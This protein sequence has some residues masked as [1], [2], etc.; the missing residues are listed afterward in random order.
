MTSTDPSPVDL[1]RII[2]SN[3]NTPQVLNDHPWAAVS[4]IEG[5]KQLVGMTLDVFRRIV[6]PSPPRTGK[7]LDTRWGA[8][9]ILAAQYFAPFISGTP[10]PSSLR[11][12]WD[13]LDQAIL[14][15]VHKETDGL[16][17]EEKARY[18]FAGNE[19]Q[20][21]PNSTL[22]DWHRKGMEQLAEMMLVERARK[23]AEK[24]PLSAKNAV[25][26]TIGLAVAS[27]LLAVVLFF[28]W[29]A[30]GLYQHA[31][32]IEQKI[33]AI[34][35]YL[36]PRPDLE[37]LP[38]IGV[39]IHDLRLEIDTL[40]SEAAPY[41]WMTKYGGWIPTYGGT[42]E[43]APDL[44][45]FAQKL[46]IAADDGLSA[47]S[48]AIESSL[49]NNQP[50]EVLDLLLQ[51]QDSSPKLLNAQIALAQAQAARGLIDTSLLL[52][53]LETMITK[54]IDPLLSSISGAFPMED[55]LAMVS[56]A[57]ELLGGGKAGPQTYLILMQNE[58]ELRPT[59]GF[60]TAIGSAVIKDGQLLNI[61]IESSEKVDDFSKPYPIPPW[62]FEEFMNIEML[63]LR[64]SNWFTDFPTTVSWTEY[65][66]SYTRASSS[67]GVISLDMNV[68]A[69][70]LKIVGPVR[71]DAVNTPITSENVRDY[72][73]AAEEAPPQG[74]DKNN[75]DRKQFIADLAQ[76]LLEK[77][78]NARG[79]T[80]TDLLPA[81]L[82]L[83]DEKHILL[84]FDNE[85]MTALLERRNWDGA[86]RIPGQSDFLMVVDANMGYNKSN[87]MME[88]ALEYSANLA[89]LKQP[90]GMLRI[91]QTN[92]SKLEIVCEPYA[93]DRFLP[94]ETAPGGISEPTYN[95][96]ECHWG[97]IRAY[98]PEGTRLVRSNP[99]EIQDTATWLG[100]AI[101][102]RTDDLGDEDIPNAQVFGTMT[103]TPTNKTTFLEF[104]YIL[105]AA[106]ITFDEVNKLYSYRLKI[107]KQPGTL[108][109]ALTFK[110]SL[111]E[112]YTVK[113]AS[114]PLVE[115]A[116]V[117]TAQLDMR[118][119]VQVEIQFSQK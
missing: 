67:D 99:Q 106:V 15:F 38:A 31:Q 104:D 18:R 108:A 59:G 62:Q 107:Q 53:R 26:K 50:L 24:K 109:H 51:L 35:A 34:E 86:V 32:A 4:E 54:R 72:L 103:L 80:W 111:P 6:P 42:L 48:P 100:K 39:Q 29:K 56:I 28:G 97:Y 96:D 55:A 112:S 57:P 9:G 40:Q 17:E 90:T 36:S 82:S 94:R 95:M 116:G 93:F 73:R 63:L 71:V 1:L 22:S 77:I 13:S 98:M 52:P 88:M 83:M 20:P 78:L 70:L 91:Q 27:L 25:L 79:K 33:T 85:E 84:Q 76:P 61:R 75:W 119:D 89:D 49:D 115:N 8:F 101:P 66:Y 11:D 46:T 87:A 10:F 44:L 58:D 41:L 5:G 69:Q 2:L 117:W 114:L 14:L 47:I 23:S 12:A 65:F 3:L 68:I 105:P 45:V 7:R 19:I 16:K 102:A 92:L 21:A 60:L 81:L 37:Q 74:A 30:W 113:G 110:L 43:Q 118:Q 64:D